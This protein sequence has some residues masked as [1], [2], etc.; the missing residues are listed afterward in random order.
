MTKVPCVGSSPLEMLSGS[1]DVRV[2]QVVAVTIRQRLGSDERTLVQARRF[3][4]LATR[5][6]SD[7]EEAFWNGR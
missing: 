7:E 6:I 5:R 3:M 2:Q 4:G 1:E